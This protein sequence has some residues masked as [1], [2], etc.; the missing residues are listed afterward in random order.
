MTT[1]DASDEENFSAEF[2][3]PEVNILVPSPLDY[4]PWH[5]PRKQ[6]VRT[7]Q[8]ER[9]TSGLIKKLKKTAF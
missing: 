1:P 4:A 7:E 5:K 3:D 6:Y 8:W 2:A 9:H